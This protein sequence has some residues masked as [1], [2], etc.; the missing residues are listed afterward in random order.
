MD[1]SRDNRLNFGMDFIL[2]NTHQDIKEEVKEEPQHSDSDPDSPQ[3]LSIRSFSDDD[4]DDQSHSPPVSP[5]PSITRSSSLSPP[6][7]PHQ[8]MSMMPMM[9]PSLLPHLMLLNQ[10]QQTPRYPYPLLAPA[11]QPSPPQHQQQP[12][13]PLKCTLRKHKADRKPRTPFTNEQL[14]KL[15]QKFEEKSYLSI[16]ERADFAAELELTETQ[17]KIWFQN[18]RAKSKRIAEAEVYQTNCQTAA[19]GNMIPPSLMPG[20]LAGRGLQYPL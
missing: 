2:G 16:A 5:E 19:R 11:P 17:I 4:S 7:F 13:F 10:L 18:R 20:I 9:P 8:P 6:M 15:E 14:N 1:L 3:D 12:Q